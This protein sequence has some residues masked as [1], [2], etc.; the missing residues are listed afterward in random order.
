MQED[1]G[2]NRCKD[3]FQGEQESARRLP[4]R[5]GLGGKRTQ[6]QRLSSV[7]VKLLCKLDNQ[8][9]RSME[10]SLGQPVRLQR[11]LQ[12]QD[13]RCARHTQRQHQQPVQ[14]LLRDGCLQQHHNCRRMGQCLPCV[15]LFRPHIFCSSES[16]LLN[17]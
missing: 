11:K 17:I 12:F 3:R 5:T 1:E 2:K 13:C 15:L 6:L 4:F 7:V 14:P 16:K 9:C 8:R 10:N